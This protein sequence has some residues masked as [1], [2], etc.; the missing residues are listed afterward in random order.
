MKNVTQRTLTGLVYISLVII[1]LMINPLFFAAV[2]VLFNG[3]AMFELKN[4]G[5]RF[6]QP[7]GVIWIVL[8]IIV[9]LI[10]LLIIHFN[11][12][13]SF[14]IPL[15]FLLI[16]LLV[17]PIFQKTGDSFSSIQFS[18]FGSMYITVPLIIINLIQLQSVNDKVPYTLA[19]FI[20]IWTNDTFAYLT[21]MAIGKHRLFERLS[22][23]K[24]WEGFFGGLIMGIVAAVLFKLFYRDSGMI[25]WILFAIVASIAAVFGDFVE[26]VLKRKADVKDSGNI[27]PGHGGILDRIDS[28]LLAGPVIYIYLMLAKLF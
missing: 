11:I 5:D 10:S 12:D 8:N 19:L 9:F 16:L 24:S 14:I 20:I 18:I 3:L 4:M 7:T 25:F 1:S 6:H 15:L 23:K 27:L 21:G 26:S 22:P 13:I 17:L 2:T 28:L